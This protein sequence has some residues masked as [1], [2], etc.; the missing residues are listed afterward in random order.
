[1][2]LGIAAGIAF[3]VVFG[4][5]ASSGWA[6]VK[7]AHAHATA[8]KAAPSCAALAFR[9]VPAGASDGEQSAGTYRSRFARLELRASVKSGAPANYYMMAGGTRLAAAQSV[10]A[11]AGNCATLK[12]MPT[13]Q[14]AADTCT[15]DRFTLVVSHADD[16]RYALLYAATGS[17]SWKY[18][19]AGTF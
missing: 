16:K 17:S 8:G 9:P 6:A 2:K 10:P 5:A 1:M 11:A 4:P 18:C 14:A 15:G 12:K 13:P 19:S 3:A 7:P